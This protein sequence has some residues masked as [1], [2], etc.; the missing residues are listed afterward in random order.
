MDLLTG[1]TGFLGHHLARRL[2][3]EGRELRA[4]VRFGTDLRRIPPEISEI[5]WGS[6]DDPAAIARATH[7]IDTI[8]HAAARVSSGGPRSSFENDNVTATESLLEA[9]EGAGI[10]RFVYVSSAGIYGSASAGSK[11]EEDTPLDPQIEKRGFYAWSKAEADRRVRAFGENSK[12]ET[13]VVRPGLL[14][15][16]EAAPFIARLH[17]PIPRT[18]GRRLII[19]RRSNLLPF[20]H[21]D[22]AS[23]ALALAATKGKP[24]HAYNVID[25][26]VTQGDYLE[27]LADA[28]VQKVRAIYLPAMLVLPLAAGCELAGRLL[29]R[30]LPLSRYKLKRATESLRYDTHAAKT[31]LGWQPGL[32]L[33]Q[34]IATFEERAS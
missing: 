9:A 12:L 31:D 16:A 34:G 15:G 26:L 11:I 2:A 6:L 22:N 8:F 20:T 25:G 30:T 13:I 4:L 28:G 24:G 33:G 3:A 10:R 23:D 1:S 7:G 17:F 19:G 14:Y 32:D 5:V 21:V 18:N 27:E 29:G